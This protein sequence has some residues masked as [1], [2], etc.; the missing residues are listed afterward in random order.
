[1]ILDTFIIDMIRKGDLDELKELL[2]KN[3]G[4]LNAKDAH[5]RTLLHWVGKEGK[6]EIAELLIKKGVEIDAKDD[7]GDTPLSCAAIYGHKAVAELLILKGANIEARNNWGRTPLH[8]V[9]RESGN[10]DIARILINKGAHINIGDK[11]GATP[12]TSAAWRGFENIVNLL[13]NEGA[14]FETTGEEGKELIQFVVTKGLVRLFK[15]MVAKDVDLRIMNSLGGTLLHSSAQGGSNEIAN[16]LIEKGLDTNKKDRY[17]WNPLHY[18][19]YWGEKEIVDI[20]ISKGSQVN[21][22]TIEG[23]TPLHYATDKN[24]HEVIELLISKGA[25][26]DPPQFPILK[27]EYL[28]QQKPGITPEVF[29]LGII[30]SNRQEH[31]CTTFSPDG[32]EVFWSTSFP[33]Q[34][35]I[36]AA[37][38]GILHMKIEDGYWTPPKLAQ[39]SLGLGED[40]PFFSPD[41]KKLFFMSRRPLKGSAETKEN[42]WVVEKKRDSWSEPKPLGSEVNSMQQHWQISVSSQGTLYFASRSGEGYGMGDIYCSKYVSGRYTKPENLGDSINTNLGE[43][44]PFIAPDESYLIFMRD[45]DLHISFRKKDGSWTKATNMGENI[46][47]KGYELCP[48]VSPDGKYLFFMSTRNGN[49]DIY[50][51]KAKVI[52]DLRK[53]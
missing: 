3:K 5:N 32:K 53:K 10:A 42:I 14:E 17:G 16:L 46:N 27:G 1:M 38:G 8:L 25:K 48:I 33:H 21:N 2:R 18:A 52:D 49:S 30:S 6:R 31:G 13:L 47:S 29:G 23:K 41:G 51:V 15:L 12:L 39:F 37:S 28:G 7:D 40:V 36:R 11:Y 24:H 9:A 34:G 4:I 43:G 35:R 50:W 19:A 26:T 44:T 22:I 20:L 45:L